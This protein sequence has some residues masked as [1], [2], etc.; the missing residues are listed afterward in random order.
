MTHHN[1]QLNHAIISWFNACM[2]NTVLISQL[3][4]ISLVITDIDGCLTDCNFY[5]TY[6]GEEIKG[7]SVHDGYAITKALQAGLKI[8]FLS[9]KDSPAVQ[10][11][12]ERLGIPPQLC[13]QGI[14]ADKITSVKEMQKFAGA[15]KETTLYLGDDLLD[16][17]A[18]PAVALFA[19]PLN[20]PFY[21]AHTADIHIPKRGGQCAFRHLLDLTLYAQNRHYAQELIDE[22]RK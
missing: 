22:A 16:V 21:I 20:A 17:E 7:F 13:H 14:S 9:G 5:Q 2:D 18:Q 10:T 8:A 1:N 4:N 3:Q 11:R 6:A 15:T 19:C 12:A